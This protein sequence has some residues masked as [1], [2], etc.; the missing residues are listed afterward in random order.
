MT[1]EPFDIVTLQEFIKEEWPEK[2]IE[3]INEMTIHALAFELPD[4]NT[5]D[6]EICVITKGNRKPSILDNLAQFED[7]KINVFIYKYEK[8]LYNWLEGPN[9]NKIYVDTTPE[10]SNVAFKRRYVQQI[11][12][13]KRY[14]VF[15]DDI[16]CGLIAGK[17]REGKETRVKINVSLSKMCRIVELVTE[18]EQR[19]TMAGYTYAEIAVG[20]CNYKSLL[21]QNKRVD[22]VILF[23]GA[24]MIDNNIWYAGDPLIIETADVF[25][26][27]VRAGFKV[28]CCP[29]GTW[30]AYTPAGKGNTI[31]SSAIR[32]TKYCAG[33]YIKWG[34]IYSFR[35]KTGNHKIED[36]FHYSKVD[37]PLTWNEDLLKICKEVVVSG[38]PEPIVKYINKKLNPVF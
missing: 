14:W 3:F 37:K 30:E 20:F 23:D 13:K 29:F 6:N 11:M 24:T 17:K 36:V 10:K 5:L 9:I 33:S 27:T 22:N 15:D 4:V 38:D 21:A 12:G 18:N 26:Q 28:L 25:I 19:W 32:H 35:N 2:P 31:S 34:D 1:K 7:T 8:D 16:K